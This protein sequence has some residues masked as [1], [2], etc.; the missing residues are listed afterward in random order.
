MS[1]PITVRV[2]GHSSVMNSNCPPY[3]AGDVISN[4]YST[5]VDN[6]EFL[7]SIGFPFDIYTI[8]GIDIG[9]LRGCHYCEL[10]PYDLGLLDFE[11]EFITTC[12]YNP[13]KYYHKFV[14][15]DIAD[16]LK[17]EFINHG[18]LNAEALI[19]ENEEDSSEP[20]E[21]SDEI[22]VAD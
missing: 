15:T 2:V 7:R 8:N 9:Y 1:K 3:Q 11:Q 22:S 19:F 10:E 12:T 16:F 6:Q 18:L 20:A 17:D 4:I 13:V 5:E 21:A 14:M